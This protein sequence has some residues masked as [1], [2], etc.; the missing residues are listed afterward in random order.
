MK[1][2]I[3]VTTLFLLVMV[4]LTI[5]FNGSNQQ[6]PKILVLPIDQKGIYINE[7]KPVAE[8][9]SNLLSEKRAKYAKAVNAQNESWDDIESGDAYIRSGDNEKAALSYEKAYVIGFS[10]QHVSGMELAR[11][12]EKL[13]RY[14]EA[15]A[16]LNQMMEKKQL[17]EA[18]IQTAQELISRLNIAKNQLTSKSEQKQGKP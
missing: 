5:V 11:T 18:G 1:K 4:V 6:K 3:L 14:D 2:I 9:K 15:I 16:L 17:S 7:S 8:S 13:G 12:Y 10:N